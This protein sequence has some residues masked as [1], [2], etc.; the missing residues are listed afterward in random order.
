MFFF[1]FLSRCFFC[2]I[3]PYKYGT[4]IIGTF[5]LVFMCCKFVDKFD[6]ILRDYCTPDIKGLLY[7][8]ASF[9]MGPLYCCMPI[10]FY[11]P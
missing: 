9:Y 4:F 7:M 10:V 11:E 2:L 8:R 1:L 3:V 6:I 5:L